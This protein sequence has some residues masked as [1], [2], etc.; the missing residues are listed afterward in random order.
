MKATEGD[1]RPINYQDQLHKAMDTVLSI[2][3]IKFIHGRHKIKKEAPFQ[4]QR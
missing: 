4:L 2:F 3:K 1:T